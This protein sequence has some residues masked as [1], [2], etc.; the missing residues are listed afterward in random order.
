MVDPVAAFVLLFAGVIAVIVAWT[1]VRAVRATMSDAN[2][3]Q[4]RLAPVMAALRE[5]RTPPPD[6]IRSLAADPTTR[7]AA[8]RL[9]RQSGR[10]DLF[11]PEY[12]TPA[13]LADDDVDR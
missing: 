4:Q 10:L 5:G 3:L 11:P 1:I 6:E 9:L 7:I 8:Y 2:L 13:A 12:A